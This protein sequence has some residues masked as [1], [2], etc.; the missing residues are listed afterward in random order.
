MTDRT[1]SMVA[2]VACLLAAIGCGRLETDYGPASGRTG[3]VSLNGFGALRQAYDNAGYATRDVRRLSDRAMPHDVIVWTPQVLDSIG[4][5]AGRWFENWL[6]EGNRTLVYVVP[7]SGSEAEYWFDAARFA[8]PDQRFE[9]RRRA[10]RSVNERLRWRLSRGSEVTE[11]WFQ[12][13]PLEQR[14]PLGKLSGSWADELSADPEAIDAGSEFRLLKIDSDSSGTATGTP[15]ARGTSGQTGPSSFTWFSPDR[16]WVSKTSTEMQP[17]LENEGGDPLIVRFTS[18]DWDDSQVLVVS[19]GSMLTNFAFTRSW[20]RELAG[21]VIA[22]SVAAADNDARAGFLTN[23]WEGVRVSEAQPGAPRATG[24][25]LLTVWPLSLV[26]I[27][28]VMLGVVLCLMLLP[29][30]GRP[31][32]VRHRRTSH[33]GDHLDA[34]AALMNKSGGEAFAR[35]RISEYMRRVRGE[36]AGPWVLPETDATIEKQDKATR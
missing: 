26:T 12:V 1:V 16:R 22:A 10:A 4:Q 19:G 33:F 15:S 28:G 31:R 6:A 9:Y 11:G 34:V 30:F 27:H 3:R 25:E 17:L 23:N 24:M 5:P 14:V 8:P 2:L 18:E 36:T 35:S 32:R 29:I 20:N 21:L 13:E 7:D